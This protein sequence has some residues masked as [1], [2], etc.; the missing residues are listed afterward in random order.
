MFYIYNVHL[1]SNDA[2]RWY[3]F[4]IVIFLFFLPKLTCALVKS[5]LETLPPLVR[6]SFSGG[7]TNSNRWHDPGAKTQHLS[8]ALCQTFMSFPALLGLSHL[9]TPSLCWKCPLVFQGWGGMHLTNSAAWMYRNCEQRIAMSSQKSIPR[10]S[11]T[12][13]TSS[14]VE[15]CWSAESPLC[16][17]YPS[18]SHYYSHPQWCGAPSVSKSNLGARD[19]SLFCLCLS[20]FV[21]NSCARWP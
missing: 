7:L 21:L 12:L 20:V 11:S 17:F 1:K 18:D 8:W 3:F 5:R 15:K 13:E 2:M 19:A 9:T 10:R 4:C 16:L 14:T 6:L